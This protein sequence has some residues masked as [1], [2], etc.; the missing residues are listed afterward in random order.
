MRDRD[1]RCK[2]RS[3]DEGEDDE[4]E[5]EKVLEEFC[6]LRRIVVVSNKSF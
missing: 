6:R 2:L 5:K 1:K 4:G 3:R